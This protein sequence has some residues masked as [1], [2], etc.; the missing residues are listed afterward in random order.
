MLKTFSE[1]QKLLEF[2]RTAKITPDAKS[3]SNVAECKRERPSKRFFGGGHLFERGSRL[4]YPRLN[5][6][7]SDSF[8]INQGTSA[9]K[10]F[11]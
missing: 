10:Y 1:R 11:M 2:A 3:S 8:A 7:G 9:F 5:Q 6:F 4:S